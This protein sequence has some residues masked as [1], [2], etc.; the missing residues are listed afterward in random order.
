MATPSLKWTEKCISSQSPEAR[1]GGVGELEFL[2]ISLKYSHAGLN[3]T[4]IFIIIPLHSATTSL[5]LFYLL[6]VYSLSKTTT[7]VKYNFPPSPMQQKALLRVAGKFLGQDLQFT[8]DW[9]NSPVFQI[10][11]SAVRCGQE[12]S[13]DISLT[14][15]RHICWLISYCGPLCGHNYQG[16]CL[17]DHRFASLVARED[18]GRY[19]RWS[20]GKD[21]ILI[22]QLLPPKSIINIFTSHSLFSSS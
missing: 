21:C 13:E 1:G 10:S 7:L 15:E 2:R 11:G 6:Y 4:V 20:D 12:H 9:A 14:E 17:K 8:I 5:P 3:S 18:R 19:V 16:L 22:F